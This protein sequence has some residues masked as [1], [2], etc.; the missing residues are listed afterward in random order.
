VKHT[1]EGD[2]IAIGAG[3]TG[4]QV[5]MW[6]RDSGPGVPPADRERIFDRF[7]RS[8]VPDNDEG[9]GLGLSIVRAIVTGHGGTARVEDAPSG[10]AQFVVSFPST[11]P[12]ERR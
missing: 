2:E 10:G 4:G 9:F 7:G 5:R 3:L 12:T 11:G 1:Q 6:V 8:A